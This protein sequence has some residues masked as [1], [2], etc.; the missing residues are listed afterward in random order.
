MVVPCLLGNVAGPA[1]AGLIHV[2]LQKRVQLCL[3][4]KSRIPDR[5]RS[6]GP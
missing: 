4:K 1:T 3:A 2:G 6:A 5:P